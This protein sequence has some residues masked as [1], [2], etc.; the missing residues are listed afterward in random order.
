MAAPKPGLAFAVLLSALLM[1]PL[2]QAAKPGDLD[3]SFSGNGKVV[4]PFAH[5]NA[6]Y[7]VAIDRRDRAVVAGGH[8]G[9][10]YDFQ[11]ARYTRRGHLN[12]SFSRNG[13]VVTEFG[14]DSIA[15]SLTIDSR[16]RIVAVGTVGRKGGG[17]GFALA[18]YKRNGSLDPSFGSGGKVTSNFGNYDA[19]YA[20]AIDSQGRIVAAGSVRLPGPP[21]D[22]FAFALA[23]YEPD[24]SPD[25]SF[26]GDGFVTTDFGGLADLAYAVAIDPQDRI[27]AAGQGYT[28]V[29]FDFAL[30]RYAP[31]G[32]LD[33]GFGSGGKVTTD[34]GQGDGA[35]GVAID[36]LGRIVAVG[37][38]SLHLDSFALA[39]YKPDGSLDPTFGGNG[40]AR[41][42]FAGFSGAQSVAIDR[43]GRLVAAG[44]NERGFALARYRRDGSRNRSFSHNGKVTTD[45]QSR[46]DGANSVALDSRG[47][48]IAAGY[49]RGHFAVTRYLGGPAR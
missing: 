25:T 12:R 44:F 14:G 29:D 38:S 34:F 41:T 3:H 39:R 43:Q 4:T 21:R 7:S 5:H 19:A 11:L 37:N 20:V 8:H 48:V 24:G 13:K 22:N 36:S 40:K 9:G 45:F 27:V 31:D 15:Q 32:S 16:G 2:A 10:H 1:P 33:S 49:G 26:S 18:R 23:R 35:R 30:A 6:A 17:G 28:G 47:R 46:Y 42:R